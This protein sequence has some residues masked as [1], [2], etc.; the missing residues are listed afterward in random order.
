M[1]IWI[2]ASWLADADQDWELPE[3]LSAPGIIWLML[4]FYHMG[5]SAHDW[6]QGGGVDDVWCQGWNWQA[7]FTD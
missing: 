1:A 4:E 6:G 2:N 7:S 5:R 3:V